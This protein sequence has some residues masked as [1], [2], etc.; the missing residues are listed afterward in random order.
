MTVSNRALITLSDALRRTR[1]QRGTRWRK[2]TVGQQA[3]LVLAHLR[4]GETYADLAVG[5]GV[6]T[7]TVFRYIREALDALAALA[8][9]L[10]QPIEIAVGKALVILDGTLL[11]IDRVAMAGRRDRPLYSGKWKCH[12]VNVQVIADRAGDDPGL[13]CAARRSP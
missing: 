5:F 10:A 6:G 4:K 12:G 11:R 8:P 2:L 9:T 7:T 3:L 13:I 1:N